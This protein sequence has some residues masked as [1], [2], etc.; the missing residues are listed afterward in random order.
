M[1][2]ISKTVTDTT[3]ESMEVQ[4]ETIPGLSI[5]TM[6][7]DLGWPWSSRSS[8]LHFRYF[9]NGGKYDGG[10][11]RIR[12]GNHPCVVDWHH[13]LHDLGW[14][15]TVLDLGPRTF[16]SNTSNA[17]RDTILDTIEVVGYRKPSMGFR[18]APWPLTLDGLELCCSRS[19]KSHVKYFK[20]GDRYDDDD[21]DGVNRSLRTW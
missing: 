1:S 19:S 21:D 16:T 18:L 12:I 7:F 8:K 13:D 2:N 4:Y 11:N 6:T 9:K 20:T 10:V 3:T 5:G 14:L 15:W 17:V